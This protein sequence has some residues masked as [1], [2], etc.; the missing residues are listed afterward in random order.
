MPDTSELL[1]VDIGDGC[2]I[3]AHAVIYMG[4]KIGPLSMVGDGAFIREGCDVGHHSLVAGHAA[5][6]INVK[7]GD[8]VRIMDYSLIAGNATIEDDV[9]VAHQV[10]TAN[11]LWVDRK[12]PETR[13]WTERG[14]TIRRFAS[15]GMGALLLPGVEIGENA[16]VG[17]GAVVTKDVRPGVLVAG[18]PARM[19]R[20][21]REDELKH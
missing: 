9:F 10:A 5:L 4:V 20:T 12:E 17:A 3:G 7:I 8:R 2:V 6:G 14:V 15:I 21:L 13:T 1:P 16:L 18:V 19:V 11:A